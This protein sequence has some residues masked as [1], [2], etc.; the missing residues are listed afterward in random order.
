M[1]GDSS[2]DLPD[3]DRTPVLLP[4]N[5]LVAEDDAVGRFAIR[6]F[7]ERMG[8]NLVCVE[9]GKQAL[10]A[11][12][13]FP[14]DCLFTDIQMPN[15]DGV[16][17]AQRLRTNDLNG[18]APTEAV[19]ILVRKVFPQ[20][21][22][23]VLSIDHGC[24]IVA[25]SAHTMAGDKDRFLRQGIDYYIFNPIDA[26]QLHD[27]LRRIPADIFEHSTPPGRVS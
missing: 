17:L 22:C 3:D 19:R 26:Q 4:L 24:L 10:Q 9:N 14:F 20:A 8:H 18:T 13:L 16:E 7:L 1:S 27:V 15:M 23:E 2:G 11:L 5:I 25:V 6:T 21:A 12:Q